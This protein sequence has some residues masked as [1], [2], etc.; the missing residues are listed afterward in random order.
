MAK[1][2]SGGSSG[3]GSGSGGAETPP[4]APKPKRRLWP[5]P[6][7]LAVEAEVRRFADA[8]A[9]TIRAADAS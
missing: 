6:D 5:G 7:A 9:E 3:G 1:S 4:P 8:I 2:T